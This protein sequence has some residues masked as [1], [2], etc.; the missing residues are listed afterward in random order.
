MELLWRPQE[1]P[2]LHEQS[3]KHMQNVV[4]PEEKTTTVTHTDAIWGCSSLGF[5]IAKGMKQN[6]GVSSSFSSFH[7]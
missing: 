7:Q 2:C 3:N 1:Q 6:P 4:F 5:K